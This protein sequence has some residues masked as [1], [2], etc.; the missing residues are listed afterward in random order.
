LQ[1]FWP[2]PSCGLIISIGIPN[3][4]VG[5]L[6]KSLPATSSP[7]KNVVNGE[8]TPDNIPDQVGYSL[9]FGIVSGRT[10]DADRQRARA[11][12]RRMELSEQEID[13]LIAAAEEFRERARPLELEG[14]R[15]KSRNHP[16]LVYLQQMQQPT[17]KSKK[18][19]KP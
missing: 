10:N 5:S 8:K 12:I 19:A 18:T 7:L 17:E 16:N 2:S 4:K 3:G 9:L 15:I 6:S 14:D 13:Q 11:F 1:L